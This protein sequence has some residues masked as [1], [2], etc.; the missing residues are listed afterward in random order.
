MLKKVSIGD[1]AERIRG[2]KLIGGTMGVL[3]AG[4]GDGY[5]KVI[6]YRR[7]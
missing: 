4:A 5:I 3:S 2:G 1:G 7:I 6:I